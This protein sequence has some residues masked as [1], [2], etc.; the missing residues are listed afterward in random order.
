MQVGFIDS[1]GAPEGTREAEGMLDTEGST[2]GTNEGM[3]EGA[4][5]RE[6]GELGAK[7]VEG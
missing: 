7:E 5:E 6:G 1:D 4:P 3:S 2:L